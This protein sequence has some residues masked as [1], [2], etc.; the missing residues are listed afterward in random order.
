MKNH[1]RILVIERLD[2]VS[3]PVWLW[4]ALRHG[5]GYFIGSSRALTASWIRRWVMR[6]T[7]LRLLRYEEFP[8]TYFEVHRLV[9]TSVNDAL[10]HQAGAGP[11]AFVTAFLR[12]FRNHPLMEVALWRALENVYT[13]ERTKTLVSLRELIDRY[14]EVSLFPRDNQ[15]PRSWAPASLGRGWAGAR[16]PGVARLANRWR[17]GIE[18]FLWIGSI[19]V[20]IGVLLLKRGLVWKTPIPQRWRVGFDLFEEGIH[21]AR[22]YDDFFLYDEEVLRPQEILHV[23]RGRLKDPQTRRYFEKQKIPFVEAGRIPIPLGYLVKRI[24]RDFWGGAVQLVWKEFWLADSS[25]FRWAAT[26]VVFNLIRVELIEIGTIT[27]LFVSRDEYGVS[28]ILRT[29]LYDERGGRTIGFGHGDDTCPTVFNS[30]QTFHAFCFP[31]PFHEELLRWNTR[32]SR[33]TCVIGAGIYG[34]D[35]THRRIQE[36]KYPPRYAQLRKDRRI[37]GAFASSFAE[38][39]FLTREMTLR[40][41]RTILQIPKRC[42]D[43]VVVIRPKGNEFSDPDFRQLLTEAGKG[44]ILEDWIGTYDLIP[45]FDLILCI[46]VST[47]GLEGMMAG[48]PVLYLD[49]TG[50]REHP[51]DSYGAGLVARSPEEL[52]ARADQ[53]LSQGKFQDPELLDRIRRRHGLRFDGKVVERF[54]EVIYQE[55]EETSGKSR[56]EEP[57]LVVQGQG[58]G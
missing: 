50:F 14:Q 41:Y 52:I 4:L 7:G 42:P 38:D 53:I 19:T 29:V 44:A 36:G 25:P 32:F 8:G 33:R 16:I 13:L 55:L 37:V 40:F 21:W 31:G 30:Y 23:V 2:L 6:L 28:H 49:E 39:F 1:S 10:V 17:A 46:A 48:K 15:D 57:P 34:L 45:I 58:T 9:S 11:A 3:F 43:V 27:D 22:P 47:V 35:G 18:P 51:Y 12:R 20:G 26:S 56:Q 24:L 54:R 5:G